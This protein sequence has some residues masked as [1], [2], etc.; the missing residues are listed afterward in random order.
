M[1]TQTPEVYDECVANRGEA[2]NILNSK[3]DWTLGLIFSILYRDDEGKVQVLTAVGIKNC[4]ECGPDGVTDSDEW[5]NT[6][7]EYAMDAHGEEFYRITGDSGLTDLVGDGAGDDLY[8]TKVNVN[9]AHYDVLNPHSETEV[10]DP[11]RVQE[12]S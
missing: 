7:Y 6:Y 11:F 9:G 1:N 5:I 2:I 12:L 8:M 10:D 4:E 3:T